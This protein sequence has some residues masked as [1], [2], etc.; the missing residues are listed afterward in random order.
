LHQFVGQF[1]RKAGRETGFVTI[2]PRIYVPV[3]VCKILTHLLLK[4][5]NKT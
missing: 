4:P 1:D 5:T 3:K 2:L